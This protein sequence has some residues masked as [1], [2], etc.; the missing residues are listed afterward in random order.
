[1][2]DEGLLTSLTNGFV[3]REKEQGREKKGEREKEMI[4]DDERSARDLNRR[5][6]NTVEQPR[7]P[8]CPFSGTPSPRTMTPK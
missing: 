1:M 3:R 6:F 4:R 7:S 5:H 2:K 8:S